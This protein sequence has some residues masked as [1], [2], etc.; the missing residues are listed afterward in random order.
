MKQLKWHYSQDPWLLLHNRPILSFFFFSSYVCIYEI[1]SSCSME[2][3]VKW[4]SEG[5]TNTFW[6]FDQSSL[7]SSCLR[8]SAS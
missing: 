1:L 4:K 7:S 8:F 2:F 5:L 6:L 3:S